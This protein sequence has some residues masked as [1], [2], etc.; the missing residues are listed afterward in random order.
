MPYYVTLGIMPCR[1]GLG[2][3]IQQ[4]IPAN[5]R[6]LEFTGKIIDRDMINHIVTK[7]CSDSFLQVG[8]N[9]FIGA[10]GRLDDYVNHSCDPNCG[11]DFED[12]RVYLKS[13]RII[14]RGSEITY[15]YATSQSLFPLRFSCKCESPDCRGDIGDFNELPVKRKK[16]YLSKSVVAPFLHTGTASLS[17]R[18]GSKTPS[19]KKRNGSGI[20]ERD[21]I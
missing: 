1:G 6:I 9:E 18:K 3:F 10:S 5:T 2:V 12:G 15:D 8:E 14:S 7:G 13:I 11:L 21:N 4:W 17:V 19:Y 16:F 20:V